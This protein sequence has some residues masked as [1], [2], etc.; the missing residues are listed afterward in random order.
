MKR[1][2]KSIIVLIFI[3]AL[4]ACH[5]SPADNSKKATETENIEI[6]TETESPINTPTIEP[7]QQL[8]LDKINE[9]EDPDNFGYFESF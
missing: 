4:T 3:I 7:W 8:Y 2:F 6:I 5:T 9:Y 1:I